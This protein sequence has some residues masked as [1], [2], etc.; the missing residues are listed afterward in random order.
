MGKHKTHEQKD[1]KKHPKVLQPLAI[2]A[3]FPICNILLV[4]RDTKK[5]Y[6]ASLNTEAADFQT[7]IEK[8]KAAKLKVEAERDQQS[9]GQIPL[10]LSGLASEGTEQ[11]KHEPTHPAQESTDQIL[12][13]QRAPQLILQDYK[14]S[15]TVDR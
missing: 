11:T 13:R 6:I 4:D 3:S 12:Q 7:V 9:S 10:A 15:R 14:A 8:Y 5:K 2:T 1:A